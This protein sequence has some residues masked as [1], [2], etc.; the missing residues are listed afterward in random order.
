MVIGEIDNQILAASSK[1]GTVKY[2][3]VQAVTLK[4]K[5]KKSTW[6]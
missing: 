6:Q 1:I 3:R 5:F 2:A 4:F